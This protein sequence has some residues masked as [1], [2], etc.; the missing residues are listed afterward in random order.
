[1]FGVIGLGRNDGFELKA[2]FQSRHAPRRQDRV[3]YEQHDDGRLS[4]PLQQRQR[5]G[6]L[7]ELRHHLPQLKD[8]RA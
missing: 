3:E 2:F 7:N 4:H 8:K 6:P 1:M 5:V